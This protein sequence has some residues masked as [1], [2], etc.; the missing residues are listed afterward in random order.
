MVR[1]AI[2]IP[3]LVLINASNIMAESSGAPHTT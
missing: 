2:I 1:V 3:F